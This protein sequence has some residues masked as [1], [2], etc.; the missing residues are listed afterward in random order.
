MT[1][2]DSE[3]RVLAPLLDVCADIYRRGWAENHAGNLS[4]RLSDA[5]LDEFPL[6]GSGPV[7]PLEEPFPELAGN[8]YLVTA[9]GSPFRL[10]IKD[11]RTHCGIVRVGEDGASLA[12]LWGFAGGR[13][14]TSELPAHLRGHIAQAAQDGEHTVVLHCHPTYVVAMTHVHPLDEVALTRALWAT[15]SESILALPRGVGLLPWM[16]CGTDTIGIE[17]ADKLREFGVVIWAHHG[18]LAS[19]ASGQA[20]LGTVES[21]EKSAQTWLL[22]RGEGQQEI[23]VPQLRDLATAFGIESPAGFLD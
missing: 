11:P 14:P 4:Y 18:V 20:V 1:D 19:G 5:E 3:H 22:T 21:L 13:R 17:S 8:S 23:T 7:L 16:V 12:V 9:A 10:L 15:N 6:D 2:T